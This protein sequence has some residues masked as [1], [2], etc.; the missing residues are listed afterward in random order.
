MTS[1]KP[2]PEHLINQIEAGKGQ[3]FKDA[4]TFH[5]HDYRNYVELEYALI[6]FI[7]HKQ[8]FQYKVI[9]QTLL[10]AKKFHVYDIIKIQAKNGQVI[11]F[12]FDITSV[13]GLDFLMHG[14]AI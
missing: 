14:M 4:I 6:R 3:T 9:D 5:S 8:Q 10:F 2:L 13:F 11:K 7:T 1:T 12:H